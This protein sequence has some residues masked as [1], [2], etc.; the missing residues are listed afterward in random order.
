MHASKEHEHYQREKNRYYRD[1]QA[2]EQEMKYANEQRAYREQRK[3]EARGRHEARKYE[4]KRAKESREVRYTGEKHRR[5]RYEEEK[6]DKGDKTLQDLRERLLSKRTYKSSDDEGY[7]QDKRRYRET[8]SLDSALQGAAGAYVKDII[9][10]ST[11]DEKRYVVV[12][13]FV[14]FSNLSQYRY[15]KEEDKLTEEERTEQE[16]RREKLLEAEREMARQKE[17][18]RLERERRHLEKNKRKVDDEGETYHKKPRPSEEMPVVTVSDNSEDEPEPE[19]EEDEEAEENFNNSDEEE[20]RSERSY[21]SARSSSES[22]KSSTRS[23]STESREA[24]PPSDRRSGSRTP[25]SDHSRSPSPKSNGKIDNEGEEEKEE[26]EK[27]IKE[28]DEDLPPYFPA[29]QGCRSVE[30]FQCLNRIEEGTY[31]VVYRARDKRTEEIVALKRLKMEK[32]KEGFPITSL[33]EINTLLK[34]QHPN[35]VTVSLVFV[36]KIKLKMFFCCHK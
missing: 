12:S 19:D 1:K 16:L 2:F 13:R 22:K 6:R 31:G 17:Q 7:K 8:E 24:T 30:E 23:Q 32:E 36:Q 18:S 34:G 10:L 3:E 35:I 27:E 28:L 26:K 25:S 21:V 20:N 11:G 15:R 29:I 5:E 4:E 14:N 9:N 33:R